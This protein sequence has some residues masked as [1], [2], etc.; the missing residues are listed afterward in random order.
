MLLII[1]W[2]FDVKHILY[3]DIC[4]LSGNA[5]Y[6]SRI[7]LC[8]CNGLY[9]TLDFCLIYHFLEPLQVKAC[10]LKWTFWNCCGS[11]RLVISKQQH[12]STKR[13]QRCWLIITLSRWASTAFYRPDAPT[14]GLH[15]SSKAEQCIIICILY[16]LYSYNHF[17]ITL[18]F[19]S[20][21]TIFV[22]LLHRNCNLK[23]GLVNV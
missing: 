23:C 11:N 15:Q 9:H 8:Y 5:W 6:H 20:C 10:Y 19:C 21:M 14:V 16:V 12:Q 2:T 13:W 7:D 3:Y 18:F 1:S 4:T 22:F 17:I